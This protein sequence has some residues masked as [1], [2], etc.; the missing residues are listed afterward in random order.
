MSRTSENLI[1]VA[2]SAKFLLL[3]SFVSESVVPSDGLIRIDIE[4]E[5]GIIETVRNTIITIDEDDPVSIV[6]TLS[7]SA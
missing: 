6:T 1:A 2:L 3:D 5:E 7:R 4:S